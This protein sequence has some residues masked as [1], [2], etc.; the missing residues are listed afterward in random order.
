MVGIRAPGSHRFYP[1]FVISPETARVRVGFETGMTVSE[2][3]SGQMEACCLP[4]L[5]MGRAHIHFI[6]SA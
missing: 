2:E 3:R 4:S 6:T 1:V 5:A